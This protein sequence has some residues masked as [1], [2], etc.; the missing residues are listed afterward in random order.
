M[1]N[2]LNK[3]T[4]RSLKL[5]I[6]RTIATCMG[7][8]MSTA[9]ICAVAGVASSFQ[10]TLI[11]H[12]IELDGD[13]HA[14]FFDISKNDQKYIFEN[15]NVKSTYITQGIGYSELK[16]SRNDY[17]PYMYLMAFDKDALNNFG[18]RVT[19]G[20]LPQNSKEV[21][22]SKHMEEN[23]GV[24]LYNV[25]DK[26]ALNLGKR[27]ADDGSELT[28]NNSYNNPKDSNDTDYVEEHIT[29]TKAEEFTVVGIIERPNIEI[30]PYSA[31][32]YSVITLLDDTNMNANNP[33]DIL[34]K[35]KNIKE[36]YDD[37]KEISKQLSQGSSSVNSEL[38]RWSGVVRNEG[39]LQMMY[40]LVGIVMGI[41]VVSS[42]FVIRNSFEISITEKMKQ[43]GMLS[44]IGATKKQIKKNVLFEGMILGLISIPIGIA[45][46]ALATEILMQVSTILVGKTMFTNE[47]KFVFNLPLLAIALSAG[48]GFLTIYFSCVFSARKAAKISPIDA[49]RSSNDI[50][51]KAKKMKCPK[52]INK[53]F[54]IGGEIAYK[55]LRRNKKKYRTT[56][57]SLVVSI[58]VFISL[59]TFLNYAFGITGTYY[60]EMNYNVSIFASC[61]GDS[62]ESEKQ[63]Y[64]YYQKF[65]KENNISKYSIVRTATLEKSNIDNYYTDEYKKYYLN[66]EMKENENKPSVI[67]MSIGDNAYKEY[68]KKIG[69]KYENYKD[70]IIYYDNSAIYIAN[71]GEDTKKIV[72]LNISAND[73]I[74]GIPFKYNEEGT[75]KTTLKIE[76]V[77]DR[78]NPLESGNFTSIGTFLISDELMDK[79]EY[80][81]ARLQVDVKNDEELCKKIDEEKSE[82]AKTGMS[83]SYTNYKEEADY[84]NKTVLLISIFLYGFITV[85]TL[86]GVTNIFNTITTNMNLR[87]KEFAMLK[88]IGMTKKEFN[89]MINL[90]SIFYGVKSLI[91]GIVLGTGISYWIYR[92]SAGSDV[93]SKL[94]FIFPT[95]PVIISIVFIA[96]I[97]GIIMKYSLNKINKQ[98]I[99]ETIRND[100]I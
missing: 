77:A 23:G 81:C 9:L 6:K 70:S 5:N 18:L 11:N 1:K 87:S 32:G 90:E 92:I 34:V 26:I 51:I 95:K 20:R 50:K 43:Y 69:G 42:V 19:E 71:N 13:Y 36:T 59:N 38:L 39:T 46:G 56:V 21:V 52:I 74:E 4:L 29:N 15:R 89:R 24:S 45:C 22:I 2:I 97:V 88:S 58:T 37:T 66:D 94:K 98:N 67:L 27:V 73:I 31:P 78:D 85:I 12:T 25:G 14:V 65:V 48:L 33:I 63:E 96:I 49:I 86:I 28:Q 47:V 93:T 44:S 100:N 8:I 62:F 99:I 80:N 16:E 10:Q 72:P 60:Q 76:K 40:G 75:E 91:I 61:K 53:I 17:K 54:G 41:I 82:L 79:F 84:Q 64:K 55:N 35:F 3:F 83:V 30:E 57:I 7:I 68:I